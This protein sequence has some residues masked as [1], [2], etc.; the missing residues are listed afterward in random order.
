MCN[1]QY[2]NGDQPRIGDKRP[3]RIRNFFNRLFTARFGFEPIN[4]EIRKYLMNE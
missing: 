3:K 4:L 2:Q 1:E